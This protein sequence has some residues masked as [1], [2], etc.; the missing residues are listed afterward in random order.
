MC[1][2]Q[3]RPSRRAS[4]R[5]A[6]THTM[7]ARSDLTAGRL[8][9]CRGSETVAGPRSSSRYYTQPSTQASEHQRAAGAVNL[10]M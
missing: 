2:H 1:E 8:Q 10:A 4:E 3:G 5:S 7:D 9:G 6:S